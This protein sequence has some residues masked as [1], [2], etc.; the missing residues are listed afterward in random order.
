MKSWNGTWT[1]TVEV[2]EGAAE[3][4]D[5]PATLKISNNR[6]KAYIALVIG[7]YNRKWSF[8]VD[9]VAFSESRIETA[10]IEASQRDVPYMGNL[11]LLSSGDSLTGMVELRRQFGPRYTDKREIYR[12]DMTKK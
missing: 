1:G 11:S 4:R 7:Y 8:E 6:E 5:Y 12:I 2:A 3:P 9:R 10:S